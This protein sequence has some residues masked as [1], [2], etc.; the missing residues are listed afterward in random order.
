MPSSR[1]TLPAADEEFTLDAL[2]GDGLERVA[3]ALREHGLVRLRCLGGRSEVLDIAALLMSEL[4]QHRDADPDGLTVIRDTGRH[5]GRVGFGGLGRGD[6]ALH[7]EC[8]Q[9]PRPP[10]LM[11]LACARA[12]EDGGESLVV[13][14]KAVLAELAASHPAA[15]EALS[16][17]RAAYFGG[18]DGH[19]APVLEHLC[20]GQ[21]RLRLRQDELARFSAEVQA[22]LPALRRAVEHHTSRMRLACGQALVLD[23]HRVLHGRTRFTGE[24]LLLRALGW[25]RPVLG[26]EAGFPSPCAAAGPA[27]TA[28]AA[29]RG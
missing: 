23:N 8:A 15:M 16:A 5:D 7:T 25:P 2:R 18:S 22:H 13:D 10:R 17:P 20:G 21:W 3:A 28:G 24:R 6:L 27:A 12:A 14:G 26:M 29:G 19:F 9:L 11:V 1:T 4:W